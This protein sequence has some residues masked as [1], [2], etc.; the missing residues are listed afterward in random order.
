MQRHSP[1]ES[2]IKIPPNLLKNFNVY[3]ILEPEKNGAISSDATKVDKLIDIDECSRDSGFQDSD[4]HPAFLVKNRDFDLV[5]LYE[6]M[7]VTPQHIKKQKEHEV[8]D[9]NGA[10][11]VPKVDPGFKEFLDILESG[12]KVDWV[13]ISKTEEENYTKHEYIDKKPR[14]LVPKVLAEP[15]SDPEDIINEVLMQKTMEK[16]VFGNINNN[17]TKGNELRKQETPKRVDDSRKPAFSA[18]QSAKK[19]EII[20]EISRPSVDNNVIKNSKFFNGAYEKV[21]RPSEMYQNNNSSPNFDVKAI[22]KDEKVYKKKRIV[23]PESQTA[24]YEKGPDFYEK[25]VVLP[26]IMARLNARLAY[27]DEKGSQKRR[28]ILDTGVKPGTSSSTNT[29]AKKPSNQATNSS[30]VQMK[31]KTNQPVLT[32]FTKNDLAKKTP[33]I[34]STSGINSINMNNVR[35]KEEARLCINKLNQDIRV[36][37]TDK[38]CSN[39]GNPSASKKGYTP[40]K[41]LA[42]EVELSPVVLMEDCNKERLRALKRSQMFKE[43]V[44]TGKTSYEG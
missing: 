18:A 36:H 13:N 16:L 8:T 30:N 19:P 12:E 33:N 39:C 35:V 37:T 24:N 15:D 38:S 25:S 14:V 32:K 26:Q 7:F 2:E 6:D 10:F 42:K 9:E 44:L 34:A 11:S 23:K 41:P 17:S 27:L 4:L 29:Q 22:T 1:H 31:P 43:F 28:L 40:E 21:S 20:P 3:D 5:D